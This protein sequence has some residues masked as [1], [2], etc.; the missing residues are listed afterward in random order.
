MAHFFQIK[1]LNTSYHKGIEFFDFKF[2][3]KTQ[4]ISIAKFQIILLLF[5]GLK[6][7]VIAKTIF[8]V[9]IWFFQIILKFDF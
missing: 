7:F 9:K 8:F 2:V 1:K 3:T 5:L 6:I 4:F